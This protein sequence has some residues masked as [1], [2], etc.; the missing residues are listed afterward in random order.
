MT[1]SFAGGVILL[2]WASRRTLQIG[3]HCLVALFRQGFALLW[4][5]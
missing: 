1:E 4:F 5:A 2:G 3:S